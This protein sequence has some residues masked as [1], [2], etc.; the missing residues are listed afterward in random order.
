MKWAPG[1][2]SGVTVAGGNGRGMGANQLNSPASVWVDTYGAI[3]V[4]DIFNHRIQ[5]FPATSTSAT[6]GT[7]VAGGN[8][9]G[10]AA[11]QL[12]QPYGVIVTGTGAIYVADRNN[13]RIQKWESARVTPTFTPNAAGSY[14]AK[15]TDPYGNTTTTNSVILAEPP[16]AS[17]SPASAT[18]TQGQTVRFVVNTN[19]S[20]VMYQWQ[21]DAGSGFV[22][23]ANDAI[24]SGV[25]SATLIMENTTTA[26]TGYTYRAIVGSGVCSVTSNSATL[27]VDPLKADLTVL[28]YAKPSLLYGNSQVNVVVDVVELNGLAST[29]LI[30][31][32][33]TQDSK[34]IL[35]MPATATMVGGRSV[36]NNVWSLSGPSNGYYVLTTNQGVGA[37]DKLSVGL[38]GNFVPGASTGQLTV[39]GTVLLSGGSE[40]RVANNVDADKLEYFQQ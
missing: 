16:T 9:S 4:A 38:L 26:L 13:H 21:I 23:L 20:G 40:Q 25:N 39:S 37:G 24:Y 34:L 31:L 18:V 1:A 14:T 17:I 11:N 35:S 15:V 3:Y 28:L 6:A 10:A 29:G 22:N 7:T 36:S 12:S 8:G 2:T 19:G 27:T 30:T 5:K 32:K 33:I